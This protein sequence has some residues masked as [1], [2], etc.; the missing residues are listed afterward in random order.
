MKQFQKVSTENVDTVGLTEYPGALI[1]NKR[2]SNIP[3]GAPIFMFNW[4]EDTIIRERV[5][6]A[7]EEVNHRGH[8]QHKERRSR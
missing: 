6:A 5:F 4:A 1:V 7:A 3:T 8:R 2:F